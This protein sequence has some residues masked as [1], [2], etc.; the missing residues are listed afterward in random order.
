MTEHPGS[1]DTGGNL[2][3][4][5]LPAARKNTSTKASKKWRRLMF[6]ASQD[7][8]SP[9]PAVEENEGYRAK[10]DKWSLGVLNDKVTDEVPGQSLQSS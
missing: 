1:L 2:G 7:A 5:H 3:N 8:S 4:S 10:P 6:S 9:A